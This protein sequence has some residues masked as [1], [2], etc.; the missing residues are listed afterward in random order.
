ME[1]FCWLDAFGDVS[2]CPISWDVGLCN[3]PHPDIGLYANVNDYLQVIASLE[4][5]E[6]H[7]EVN[8]LLDRK[9]KARKIY[10]PKRN[11]CCGD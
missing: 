1:A 7:Q 10:L 9:H 11:G 6:K 5:L 3:T 8:R 4:A 2:K